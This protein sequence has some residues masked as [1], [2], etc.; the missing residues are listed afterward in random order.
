MFRATFQLLPEMRV[1]VLPF[2]GMNGHHSAYFN[3]PNAPNGWSS[4]VEKTT[5]CT[6]SQILSN[7]ARSSVRD[8]GTP[9]NT[10]CARIHSA[11]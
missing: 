7:L 11:A 1:P 8:R 3:T 10:R 5:T 9:E 2:K 6:I 4:I